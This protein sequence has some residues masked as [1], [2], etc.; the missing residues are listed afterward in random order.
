[1]YACQ[2]NTSIFFINHEHT[3]S[4]V[5]KAAALNKRVEF[6]QLLEKLI[7]PFKSKIAS[8][9]RKISALF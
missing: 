2:D 5:S 7:P 1:M 4:I 3:Y 8:H 9:K 6:Q